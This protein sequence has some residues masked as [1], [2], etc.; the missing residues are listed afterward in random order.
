MSSAGA[1]HTAPRRTAAAPARVPFMDLS[2]IHGPLREELVADFGALIDSGAFANGPAV[3]E[4]ER[5]FADACGLPHAV[6]VASGLDAIRLGLLAAGVGPGDEV[7][8][9]ANTFA[10]TFEAVVQAGATPVVADVSE[11][12]WNLDPDA[13]AA[14]VTERTRA[15][16]PVHLYGQLADMR[17]LAELARARGLRIVEDAAQA[18]GAGRDGIVPGAAGDGAAFSFYPGK[19]LGAMG[20]GGAYVTADADAAE[21]LR[22]LREHGQREKYRHELVGYTSRLDTIQA[23]VLL[24]KLPHLARWNDERRLAADRYDAGLAGVGDLVLPPVAE[25]SDPVWHLYVVLTEDPPALA[26]FLAEAGIATGRHYPEPPHLAAAYASLGHRPGSFPVAERV[27]AHGLSL[28][29]FPGITEAEQEHVIERVRAWFV[30][31]RV[32]AWFRG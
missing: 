27:S 2:R 9:P 32:R 8:V 20:D 4:F 21:R 26:A 16:L 10:A 30:V 17:A 23:L 24:R 1:P 5:A 12:D 25:G 29:M 11:R 7:V 28:P 31:D 15:L 3:A 19:N 14:A 22:A 6:G 13:A 18:H